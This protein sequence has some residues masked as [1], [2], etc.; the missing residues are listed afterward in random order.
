MGCLRQVA[1]S[2][3]TYLVRWQWAWSMNSWLLS[4]VFRRVL[5]NYRVIIERLSR[6]ISANCCSVGRS[7]IPSFR[8]VLGRPLSAVRAH[9]A[10]HVICSVRAPCAPTAHGAYYHAYFAVTPPRKQLRVTF[11]EKQINKYSWIFTENNT[12]PYI[13]TTPWYVSELVY[14]FTA[15]HTK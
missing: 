15:N 12:L 10:Y 14:L 1:N 9:G 4:M 7:V 5:C 11:S 6:P 3:T 2:V 8:L 13:Q